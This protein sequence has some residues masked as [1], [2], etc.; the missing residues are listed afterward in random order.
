MRFAEPT[1]FLLLLA[2]PLIA[3][4]RRD[5]GDQ[6]P[7]AFSD[8]RFAAGVP[9]SWRQRFTWLPTA[10]RLAALALLIAALAR[11]Q[12]EIQLDHHE[13]QGIAIQ[14][15]VDVS[16]SM[17]FT[18]DYKGRSRTRME[19]AKQVLEEFVLG[20]GEDLNGRPN[21]LVGII[22]FARY[23]DTVCPLTLGHD[24]LVEIARNLTINDRPN[25]D[26]TAYGDAAALAAARM[27][28][29]E[30]ALA[31]SGAGDDLDI[32][33][34]IVVLLTDG[35]NNCGKHL[36]L[37][38]AAMAKEWDIR[39]YTISLG[40]KPKSASDPNKLPAITQTEALLSQ[41]A[42]DTGGIFRQAYDFESLRS[43]YAEIDQ[44]EKSEVRERQIMDYEEAYSP[45]CIFALLS[46][47]AGG[48]VQ[49]V[50]LEREP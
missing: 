35:E 50:V 48:A 34:K 1:V 46:L 15:V 10:C 11:P 31:A 32:K 5:R 40:E 23:A 38:A 33:S 2:I 17:D 19:V 12:K 6:T 30:E 22:T 47:L 44:L 45:F 49:A 39:I 27:K 29:L 18:I 14:M 36:P 42:S 26:G 37:Q 20:N 16:S 13:R 7:L 8:V 3:L 25:E 43:V 9:R 24:A 21:D 28:T 41:M 4:W